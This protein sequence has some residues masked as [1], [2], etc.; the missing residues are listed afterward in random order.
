MVAIAKSI[1]RVVFASAL[2]AT[3][4][5]IAWAQ[6]S[7]QHS[8]HVTASLVAETRSLVPGQPL[9]LALR[10]QIPPGW[11]TYWSN[12]GDS[13][14]P[15]TIDWTLPRGFKAGPIMWPTPERFAY[16]PVV[17]YG[18]QHD[19]LLPVTIETPADLQPGGEYFALCSRKLACLLGHLHPRGCRAEH[20]HPGRHRDRA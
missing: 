17:D 5:N 9:H 13:G 16:G 8:R 20:C 3:A 7:P 12:P 1:C 18:Y 10:Q 15:T 19:V 4:S 11:H 14:L 2:V 6:T